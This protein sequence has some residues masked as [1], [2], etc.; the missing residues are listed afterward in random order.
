MFLQNPEQHTYFVRV[1]AKPKKFSLTNEKMKFLNLRKIPFL[2]LIFSSVFIFASSLYA[3]R[4]PVKIYTSADGLGSGF[5]DSVFRDSRGFMWFCTRDGLSRFD[6]SR[7]INYQVSENS[8]P[9]IEIIYE[10]RNGMYWISTTAGTYRFNPNAISKPNA[11]KPNLNAEFI[12]DARGSFLEDPAGNLWFGS[13][14][15]L[16]LE[17]ENGKPVFK[18][19]DLNLPPKPGISFTI[20]DMKEAADGSLW[21][22]TSWG[23][24]RRLP[25]SRT[26]FYP[27]DSPISEGTSSIFI[28]K[29]GRIWLTRTQQIL[30]FKPEPAETLSAEKLAIKSL[31]PTSVIELKPEETVPLPEKSGEIFELSGKYYLTNIIT[32]RPFQSSDG[33]IWITSENHLLEI[34]DGILHLHT[35]NQGLSNVMGRMEEDTAG[36]LWIAGQNGVTRIDRRG[37]ITYNTLDGLNAPRLFAITEDTDGTLYFVG[38]NFYLNRFDGKKIQAVRP[39]IEQ[40]SQTIWT[41]RNALISKNGDWWILTNARLYRFS[42]VTNFSQLDSKPPSKIYTSADGL[43]SDGMFQIYE[44]SSGDIWVST[45]GKGKD[46][47]GVARLKKDEEKFYAFGESDGIPKG[48]SA[49]SFAE[50]SFGNLWISFYDGGAARFDG[51]K[52]QYFGKNEGL[53]EGLISDIHVDKKGRL[54]LSST[55]RGLIRLD[56]TSAKTPNFVYFTADNGLSSNNIR[57]ITEDNF[58]RIYLGTASGIDRLSPDTMRV[59]HYSIKDGLAA[60]FV[61]DS[62]R[63]RN[64]NLWFATQN[65]VSR[66]TPLPDEKSSAPSIFI[67]GLRISGIE[68]AVSELGNTKI[69]IEELTHTENNLQIDFFGLDFRAGET[70]QYQYKLEGVDADWSPPSEQRTITFANLSPADYRFLVRALTAEGIV[71]ENPAVVSFRILPPIWARWWFIALCVLAVAVIV[72]AFYGYRLARLREINAALEEARLAEE[73]LRKA[74]AER[75]AELEKVRSRIATDLH[76][77]I[78]ASLT[79][80]AVLSEVAQAQSKDNGASKTL[81]KITDVSNELVGTMS[82][83]VWSINPQKDHLSDLTQRMRRFAADVL[84]AKGIVFQFIFPESSRE[85]IV[86]ANIRR[87]VFLIFKESVNNIVK[88]SAAKRAEIKLDISGNDLMLKIKDDGKGFE[89]EKSFE[90]SLSSIAMGG[91]GILSIEKRAREMQGE[92]IINSEIGKGTEILLKLPLEVK[93]N[94][95]QTTQA[96][97]GKAAQNI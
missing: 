20:A 77:D 51:E 58:G 56:D 26:I 5:V 38:R 82:D 25:D 65:G 32:K 75:L 23:L 52:F 59:K 47:H 29:N 78:G 67:G 8:S 57:T 11:L 40:G 18:K 68:Q 88:H 76:D 1:S 7:F 39:Q 27:F 35:E 62:H 19:F 93:N 84:S 33:N 31:A 79:Q 22:N 85:I 69:T 44:D 54:W 42:G 83:I 73:N 16:R 9:G 61:V 60:D 55:I 37:L 10:T 50:D 41:S 46:G 15:F 4:L 2:F 72:T 30:V 95:V 86:N 71:S 48:F 92:F 13:G 63:D 3:E 66:L 24:V 90:N 12:T 87:E 80:I 74:Q 91:N 81:T 21:I 94:L 97:G 6:G 45:R 64:G 43:K 70:L 96:G 17:E 28:D 49:S 53:P 14:E 89:V 36:N 34:K